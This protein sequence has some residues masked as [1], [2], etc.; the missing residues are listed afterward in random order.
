MDGHSE[1]VL[2][3][4]GEF[5][6]DL[7]CS[8]NF[9]NILAYE[10]VLLIFK[11]NFDS[12]RKLLEFS[13]YRS[14]CDLENEYFSCRLEVK[15]ENNRLSSDFDS[16]LEKNY[17]VRE[18]S[19][20]PII[21]VTNMAVGKLIIG[22]A[23]QKY[24]QLEE[25]MLSLLKCINCSDY[26]IPPIYYC[27]EKSNVVC[28]GCKENHGCDSCE[29]S[30]P[31][32]NISLDGIASLLTYPCKY[33]RNG[34]TFTSKSEKISE[35]HSIC[36]M[37]DSPCPFEKT[38]LQCLWRSTKKQL[39]EHIENKH[40]EYLYENNT[41]IS[42]IPEKEVHYHR[43][44]R[45][46]TFCFRLNFKKIEQSTYYFTVQGIDDFRHQYQFE[47]EIQNPFRKGVRLVARKLCTKNMT[48]ISHFYVNSDNYCVFYSIGKF[49]VDNNLRFKVTIF[50]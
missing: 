32:R 26:A 43:I 24:T 25:E 19:L 16:S 27:A 45:F 4:G 5:E 2:K 12:K 13:L 23:T 14:K 50:K 1:L 30:A 7:T 37:S 44:I 6:L 29:K 49:E 47:I 28:S 3:N 21:C 39:L 34:C 18:I 33:K 31:N 15:G 41:L 38:N 11:R 40:S 10:K 35:H 9:L 48:D 42:E 46:S 8:G 20:E 17:N 22:E 36:E